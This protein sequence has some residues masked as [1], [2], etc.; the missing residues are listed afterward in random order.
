MVN[1]KEGWC[2]HKV[3]ENMGWGFEKTLV[4]DETQFVVVWP[5]RWEMRGG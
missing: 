2:S 3:R 5:L 1:R 4:C